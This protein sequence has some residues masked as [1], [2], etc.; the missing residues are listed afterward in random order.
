M[1]FKIECRPKLEINGIV[2]IGMK[3]G[4]EIKTQNRTRIKNG[5]GISL[6]ETGVGIRSATAMESTMEEIDIKSRT[7]LRIE[8]EIAIG[9][10]IS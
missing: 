5:T 2:G 10:L 9:V 7:V 8:N 4:T 1:L 6:I 3:G